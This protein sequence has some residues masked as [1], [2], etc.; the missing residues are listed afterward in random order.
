LPPNWAAYDVQSETFETTEANSVRFHAVEG[1]TRTFLVGPQAELDALINQPI[2]ELLTIAEL[3]E[4][5]ANTLDDAALFDIPIMKLGEW[6]EG[7]LSDDAVEDW[8]L[9]PAAIEPTPEIGSDDKPRS[10]RSR[11]RRGR[12]GDRQGSEEVVTSSGWKG[13]DDEFPVSVTFRK[14]E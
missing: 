9:R 5:D 7:D 4:Q 12:G 11:R 13:D 3:P 1:S 10:G 2:D 6:M 14:R 8:L